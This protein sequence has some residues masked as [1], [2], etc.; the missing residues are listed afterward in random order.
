M[1]A[2]LAL[3]AVLPWL[4]VLAFLFLPLRAG[5]DERIGVMAAEL[6]SLKESGDGSIVL[7][8][9]FE[10]ELPQALE[11]AV[12][13]GIAL[14]FNI[15]FELFR[16]RWYWF[17][18]RIASHSLVYRLSYSPLTRQYRLARGGLSQPFESLDEALALVKSVRNW[19]VADKGLLTPRED[20]DAQV[21]MRLDVSQLPKPFQVNAITSREWS[22]A[23]DWRA[24]QVPPDLQ[25]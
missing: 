12:Q 21:R 7:N 4:A 9:T 11:D 14:Y 25:R 17:D 23:S 20:Y 2:N 1:T 15:E 19:K 6:E 3:R 13:K 22:L 18:R 10:F 8:A 16:K 24:V 5:A